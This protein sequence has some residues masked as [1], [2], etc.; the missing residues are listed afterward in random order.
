ME[1]LFGGFVQF[2]LGFALKGKR[3]LWNT[4]MLKLLIGKKKDPRMLIMDEVYF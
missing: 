3:E 4:V 1:S 2:M